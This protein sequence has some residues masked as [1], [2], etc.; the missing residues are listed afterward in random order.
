MNAYTGPT[1]GQLE[2]DYSLYGSSTGSS[3]PCRGV[4]NGLRPEHAWVCP[5][6]NQAT[7]VH[8]VPTRST[9]RARYPV[10]AHLSEQNNNPDVARIS[11][12]EALGRRPSECAFRGELFVASQR[13][14]LKPLEL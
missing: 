8:L 13:V 10:L 3:W 14:P 9:A 12:E 4:P 1:R 11:A 6:G 2:G 5:P 7:N